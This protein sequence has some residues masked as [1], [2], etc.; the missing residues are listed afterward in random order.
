MMKKYKKVRGQ[1]IKSLTLDGD[2]KPVKYGK[3]PKRKK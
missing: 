3:K 1:S 2:V